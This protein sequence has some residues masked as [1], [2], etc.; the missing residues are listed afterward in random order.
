MEAKIVYNQEE[1]KGEKRL[2]KQEWDLM[3]KSTIE[4]DVPTEKLLTPELR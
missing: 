2:K 4:S 1:V 3:R